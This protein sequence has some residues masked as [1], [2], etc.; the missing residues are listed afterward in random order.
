MSAVESGYAVFQVAVFVCSN[1]KLAH[2]FTHPL[3]QHALERHPKALV[4]GCCALAR[5]GSRGESGPC[6]NSEPWFWVGIVLPPVRDL[7]NDVAFDSVLN[8]QITMRANASL[9]AENSGLLASPHE[10]LFIWML[11]CPVSEP[12]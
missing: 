3:P 2:H 9:L 10:S 6:R 8:G 5:H 12:G 11:N 1:G 7:E 4:L